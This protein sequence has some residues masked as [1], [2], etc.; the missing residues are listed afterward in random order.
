MI[1]PP[2]HI[3]PKPFAVQAISVSGFT[4]TASRSRTATTGP[5]EIDPE[6]SASVASHRVITGSGGFMSIAIYE[7]STAGHVCHSNIIETL[8]A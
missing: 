1:A 8:Y 6:R 5:R 4:M 7:S 2:R 3:H